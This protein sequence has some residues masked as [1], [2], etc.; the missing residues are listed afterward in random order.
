LTAVPGGQRSCYATKGTGKFIL[1]INFI[2]LFGIYLFSTVACFRL[3]VG[4]LRLAL[5]FEKFCLS[6]EEI[7]SFV[8]VGCHSDDVRESDAASAAWRRGDAPT[9]SD[10]VIVVEVT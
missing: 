10:D 5:Q 3:T 2:Y 8:D 1:F 9:R 4:G 7:D 6:C